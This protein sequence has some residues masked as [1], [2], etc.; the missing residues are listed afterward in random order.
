MSN[1]RQFIKQ[2]LIASAALGTSFNLS[3]AEEVN[4]SVFE[5]VFEPINMQGKMIPEFP[6]DIHNPNRKHSAWTYNE[7]VI[8][9]L[10][11]ENYL[12]TQLCFD[13]KNPALDHDYGSILFS[14]AFDRNL[15]VYDGNRK[16][17]ILSNRLVMLMRQVM[18]RH[19][20]FRKIKMTDLFIEENA[21]YE[22][23]NNIKVNQVNSKTWAKSIEIYKSYFDTKSFE[24]LDISNKNKK[25]FVLGVCRNIDLVKPFNGQMCGIACLDNRSVILGAY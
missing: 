5:T 17:S 12:I 11:N 9:K 18:R 22:S 23:L 24:L 3:Y 15:L 20:G 21:Q 6:L 16:D 13:G 8:L 19:G 10:S 4:R 7:R 14:A 2:G 25:N 1:R